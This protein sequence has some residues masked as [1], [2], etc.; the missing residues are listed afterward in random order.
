MRRSICWVGIA[1]L[2]RVRLSRCHDDPSRGWCKFAWRSLQNAQPQLIPGLQHRQGDHAMTKK[3][4][5]TAA[6]AAITFGSAIALR[7][8]DARG[9]PHPPWARVTRSPSPSS[10]RGKPALIIRANRT[11]FWHPLRPSLSDSN[12]AVTPIN[13]RK[14]PTL[15]VARF[16]LAT[17]PYKATAPWPNIA[18][19]QIVRPVRSKG[20]TCATCRP[21][22]FF[23]RKWWES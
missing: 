18:P 12:R 1:R 5:K 7:R 3:T 14:E 9:S 23:P 17:Q 22:R 15:N 4:T 13:A 21:S 20:S 16:Y 2:S 11:Q 8:R 19:P 10:S 6:V